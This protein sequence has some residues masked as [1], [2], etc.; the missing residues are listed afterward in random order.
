MEQ[1]TRSNLSSRCCVSK[2]SQSKSS[3]PRIAST[4]T[5]HI[6]WSLLCRTGVR[7]VYLVWEK[8]LVTTIP[9]P[10]PILSPHCA[11]WQPLAGLSKIRKG[12][13]ASFAWLAV[14][15]LDSQRQL[16]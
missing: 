8:W 15:S 16:R 14:Q 11:L 13:A 9:P 1:E 6:T 12:A 10:H 7:Y 4:D 2:S 5:P 3:L